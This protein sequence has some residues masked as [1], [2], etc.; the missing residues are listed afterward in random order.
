MER[1]ERQK[2]TK[3][4]IVGN[5]TAV[6]PEN[7][8]IVAAAEGEAF[9]LLGSRL[10]TKADSGDAD[11]AFCLVSADVP[12]GAITPVHRH[13]Y[14]EIFYVLSGRAEFGYIEN[15]IEKWTAVKEGETV[16]VPS[17]APH[18]F[19]NMTS[20]GLRMLVVVTRRHQEFFEIAGRAANR[21]H[22]P[23]PATPEELDRV[24]RVAAQYDMFLG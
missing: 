2:N 12:S 19:R 5:E 9:D 16:V 10:L 18:G 8:K 13:P 23:R 4:N 11:G 24:V 21:K 7:L 1:A 6:C 14:P 3:E 22:A 17:S 20:A 15:G